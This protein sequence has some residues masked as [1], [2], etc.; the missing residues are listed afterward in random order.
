MAITVLSAGGAW[1]Q[2]AG[3]STSS[4]KV[5]AA[6][7]DWR[8]LSQREINCV[9]QSLRAQ[10]SSVWS[11]IQRGINPS[12]GTVAAARASCRSQ[13]QAQTQVPAH[14]PGEAHAPAQALAQAP[15]ARKPSQAAAGNAGKRDFWTYDGSL[16][17]SR[18]EGEL[19]KFYYVKDRADS[20]E[21]GADLGAMLF[22]GKLSNRKFS[23]MAYELDERCG[24]IA[25]KV[26]GVLSEGDRR[27]EL[28]GQKPVLDKNCKGTKSEPTDLTFNLVDAAFVS[29]DVT[30]MHKTSADK[31]PAAS[32]TAGAT[33]KAAVDTAVA[34][35]AAI[36]LVVAEMA[37]REVASVSK[38][39]PEKVAPEKSAAE[40]D[41]ADKAAADK[42]A[43]EKAAAEKAAAEKAAAE[44]AAAEKAAAEKVAAEKVAAEKAAAEK[45]AAEKV[46]VEKA[47]ADKVAAETTVE[48]PVPQKPVTEKPT[49][50]KATADKPA[51]EAVLVDKAPIESKS[52]APDR[53]ALELARAEAERA[54]AEAVKAQADAERA[55]K[56]AEKAI[57]DA[58]SARSAAESALSFIY[59]LISGLSLLALGAVAFLV[60]RRIGPRLDTQPP[61]STRRTQDEF[62]RLV[63]SVL[64]EQ[65]RRKAERP[66]EP[67][68]KQRT[69]EP[70]PVA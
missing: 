67:A 57:V 11:L 49:R 13:T 46:A 15:A 18:A 5:Q 55:R 37:I 9:D 21:E 66:A 20:S 34:E 27:V 51:P 32:A 39:S 38:V 41:A 53:S 40:K 24:R 60:V 70:A 58:G 59:G 48:K 29:S 54:K 33:D 45:I 30:G 61:E 7:A 52:A 17:S 62:D 42:I 25:Y 68:R 14:A 63:A 10:R 16:L 31:V 2:T 44:K 12:D 35:K 47:A 3:G 28:T 23:G 4:P 36:D 69:E 22:E 56:E 64:H 19:R 50:R 6:Y 43:A 26:L 8:K 1:A 65:K